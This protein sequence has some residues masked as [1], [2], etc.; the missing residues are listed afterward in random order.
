MVG[1]RVGEGL[2]DGPRVTVGKSDTGT[3][4]GVA[5]ALVELFGVGVKVAAEAIVR[6]GV[7]A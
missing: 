7:G 1:G 2:C 6:V 4:L 5:V 3:V